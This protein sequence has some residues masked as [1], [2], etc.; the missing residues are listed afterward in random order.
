MGEF[1]IR[2]NHVYVGNTDKVLD[3]SGFKI[4]DDTT[5]AT[6][7]NKQ[8]LVTQVRERIKNYL[9]LDHVNIWNRLLY[10]SWSSQYPEYS[11]TRRKGY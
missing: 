5:E 3:W 9:Q 11:T 8:K 4:I 1:K 6:A 7:E 10:T 2:K